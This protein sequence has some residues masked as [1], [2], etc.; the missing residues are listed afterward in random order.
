MRFTSMPSSIGEVISRSAKRWGAK[1]ALIIGEQSWS[2]D[3]LDS[4]SSHVAQALVDHGIQRGD[5]VSLYAANCAEWIITYYGILKAGAVANPLNLMLTAEE[6]VFAM[7]DCGAKA[8][9]GSADRIEGL[10]N[11]DLPPALGLRVAFGAVAPAGA[12]TFDGFKHRRGRDRDPSF[13]V[14]DV[15]LDDVSTIGY[16]S[17]TT[18]S[19]KGAVLTHRAILMNAAMTSTMH[20]RNADDVVASALPCSHVYGNIVMNSTIACGGTLVLH[21]TFNTAQMLG[22]I[23]RHRCTM[24]EGVPTMYMYMLADPALAEADLSSL[25]RCTVGGQTMPEAKMHAV[26]AAI[27]C[28]LIELWGMT[29]LGGLGTTHSAYGPRRLGSIGVPLPHLQAR[30]ASGATGKGELPA[31]EVG[32]LQIR[33]PVVM[34]EYLGRPEA[35]KEAMTEDGWL[36]TGDLARMDSEGYIYVVDRLKDMIITGG[37]NVYPAELERV[38]AQHP[39]IAMVAV[40]GVPDPVKGELANAFVVLKPDHPVNASELERYCRERLAAYKVPRAFR[41]VA[42]LPQTSSG[43]ILRRELR[44]AG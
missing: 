44:K 25:T 40:A 10:V 34:K 20:V 3:E 12:W 14:A 13:P 33:G 6:A 43:K 36:R 28:P 4:E 27:G 15:S 9:F 31:G 8:V 22:S 16:T 21:R 26:E 7:N 1:T 42:D 18:G 38:I 17:G 35:T 39:A 19:P 32:E 29:E 30:I 41:F 11:V 2:F 23:A 37:F 5:R 24:F